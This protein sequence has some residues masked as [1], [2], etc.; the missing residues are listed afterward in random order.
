MLDLGKLLISS[1]SKWIDYTFSL[2]NYHN[3]NSNLLFKLLQHTSYLDVWTRCPTWY[4]PYMLITFHTNYPQK[5]KMRLLSYI[6]VQHQHNKDWYNIVVLYCFFGGIPI[7]HTGAASIGDLRMKFWFCVFRYNSHLIQR[8]LF[9]HLFGF[10]I[11]MCP[12]LIVCLDKSL[13]FS[14]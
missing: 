1:F 10:S 14:W 3:Y 7:V 11:Q 2:D 5:D 12:I 13:Q 9:Q 6:F 8:S 4:F